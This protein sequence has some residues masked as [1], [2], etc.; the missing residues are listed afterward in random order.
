M[1]TNFD[2]FKCNA[3]LE[4]FRIIIIALIISLL[5]FSAIGQ[6]SKPSNRYNLQAGIKLEYGLLLSHHLELDRFR[7]HFPAIEISIQSATFGKKRWEA[8]Y[9][10]PLLGINIWYSPLGN[11]EE[12]GSSYAIYPS[13][14]FPLVKDNIHSLNF[15][16][17]VGVGYL[18][19]KY[20]RIDNYKNF[21]I[22]SHV[23]IAASLHFE[24]RMKVSRML[25]FVAGGGLTHFSNGS[26]KTP[27]YGLNI[28]TATVGITSYIQSPNNTLERKV[29]PELYPYEFDGRK[30]LSVEFAMALAYKDQSQQFGESF[31]VYSMFTNLMARVSYKSKFGLGLDLTHDG[32]DKIKL[33]RNN[34]EYQRSSQLSKIGAN[35]AYE[36][37]MDRMTFL[38][39]LG[40]YIRGLDRSEGD[41]YQRL[42]FKYYIVKNV[43]ANVVLSAHMGKAEYVGFGLGYRFKFIYMRKVKHA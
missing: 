33:K 23:N 10:Y 29:L 12:L 42:T 35:I 8:E 39:N 22:G 7:S 32:S 18:T 5:S 40:A 1:I 30:Y 31:F 25:T 28:L 2:D 36:L 16:L 9:G 26:M 27:N 17:G 37:V 15:K 41:I 3:L 6:A 21:A 24:Y 14:N 4:N 20:N 11:F 43:Y 34:V 19:N 38:F 13:I